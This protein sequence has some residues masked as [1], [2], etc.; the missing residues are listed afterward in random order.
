MLGE[1][2]ARFSAALPVWAEL[3]E[4]CFLPE[5]LKARFNSVLEERRRRLGL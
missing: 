3:V 1:V 5:E 4:Q 2:L